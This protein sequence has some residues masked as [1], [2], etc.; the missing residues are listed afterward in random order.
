MNRHL[1]WIIT[2]ASVLGLGVPALAAARSDGTS[3]DNGVP[4][5]VRGNCDEAEHANDPGCI[6]VVAP[7]PSTGP[8]VVTVPSTSSSTISTTP[9]T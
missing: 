9:S 7:S 8:I 6:T 2:G 3:D 4:G 5:D 1:I